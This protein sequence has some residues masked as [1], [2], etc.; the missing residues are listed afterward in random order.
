MISIIITTA[1]HLAPDLEK[2]NYPTKKFSVPQKFL[3]VVIRIVKL[4][5]IRKIKQKNPPS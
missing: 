2:K 1:I 5:P 3:A 4:K